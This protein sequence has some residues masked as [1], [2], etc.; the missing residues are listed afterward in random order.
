MD[1]RIER[2]SM[3]EVEVSSD[4]LWKAQTQRSV[5]NFHIGKEKMPIEL[6]YSIVLLK[7][8]IAMVHFDNEKLDKEKSDAIIHA[9]N[10][11][12]E[13]KFDDQFP[14]SIWQTGSGTQTNMNI[15]E[16]ISSIANMKYNLQ[17]HPNDDVNKSQST[18]DVFPSG[19]HIAAYTMIIEKLLP[20]L[21]GLL[22]SF[23]KFYSNLDDTI[24][25]GRTHLQDATPLKVK[26]EVSG[27]IYSLE[28]AREQLI[29]NIDQIKNLAIG[30]SAVGTGINT[31]DHFGE[32]VVT[33]LNLLTSQ[34][35]KPSKNKFFELSSKNEIL[36]VHSI[37]NALATELLRIGNDIRWLS[38]GPRA[39]IGEYI[40]PSNE[41]GSSIMPGKVNPTQVEALSMVCAQVFGNQASVSFAASQGNFQLNVYMPL[42]AYNV[43]QSID[44]LSDMMISFD[45]NLVKGI[46]INR[47]TIKHHLEN[48]LM[49]VTALNPHIGYDNSAKLAKYAHENGLNLYEA[50][51]KLKIISQEE[52]KQF[53]DPKKMV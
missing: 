6:I 26:H 41:P 43:L 52:L 36:V 14:L 45:K 7:K 15:N 1:F 47:E 34:E 22:D 3:G 5:N 48:S 25:V 24:K 4:K 11:I 51:E 31:Y 49:I 32:M 37:L 13:G 42:I 39:G 50:N 33:K 38:S 23:K 35:F 18:N 12:L 27:W 10:D 9:C 2:D 8:A 20:S 28:K 44:L 16:V 53:L 46:D 29:L 30:G 40:I 17:I 21:D 19:I